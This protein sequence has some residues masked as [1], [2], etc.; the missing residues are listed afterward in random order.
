MR[1]LQV[2]KTNEGGTWAYNQARWLT[3]HGVE[4]VTVLPSIDGGNA[5]RYHECGMPVIARDLSL[6]LRRPWNLPTRIKEI[7]SLVASVSPDIIHCHFVTNIAML[8]IALR[9]SR[10]PR[11]FQ[12][13]GPLHLE[14][15]FFRWA[16]IALSTKADSWAGSCTRTCEIYQNA[17]VSEH[18]VFLNYYGGAG[19]AS[20]DE[21]QTDFG[22]LRG[23]LGLPQDAI[24]VG[25]VSYFYAPKRYLLQMRG[26]KGHE[27]FIDAIALARSKNPKI[28]GVVVG[29]GWGNAASY[30]AKVKAYAEERCPGGVV[31]TGFRD[32][33]KRIYREFAVAVHP[34]HS[35]NL[36]GAAESLAA[37]VPTIATNIGGF[38]DIVID[39]VTGLLV[40]SED[41]D[42]LAAAIMR[43][44]EDRAWAVDMADAGRKIVCELLDLENTGAA[45]LDTYRRLVGLRDDSA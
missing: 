43:L 31:F 44:T 29:D 24:L 3:E 7:R 30:V 13:P 39:E 34:S 12:V 41:P 40:P 5:D 10:I 28:V 2:V 17:G 1:V 26:L 38:P 32:D 14:H 20:C 23:E 18:R 16:E 37:G 19:G 42:A 22:V 27:D 25:M 36:G 9:G 33:L 6:P 15:W 11:L 8:R 21:Y 4:V 45:V 35:E